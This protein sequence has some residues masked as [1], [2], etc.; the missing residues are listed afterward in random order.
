M[1]LADA[2]FQQIGFTRAVSRIRYVARAIP[3]QGWRIWNRKTQRWWGEVYLD[4]PE[5]LL[6]ELNRNKNPEK[7]VLLLK[8]AQ[9]G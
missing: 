3:G 8:Q 9:Q 2:V 4:F 7:L 1:H 5:G 6:A